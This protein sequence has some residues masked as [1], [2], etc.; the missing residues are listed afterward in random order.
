MMMMMMSG[1]HTGKREA[2]MR[3]EGV[4]EISRVK[5]ENIIDGQ[6]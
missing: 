4:G 1:V 6:G 5:G 3:K 2:E